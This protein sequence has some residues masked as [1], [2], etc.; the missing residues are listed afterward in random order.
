MARAAKG[1]TLGE[2]ELAFGKAFTKNKGKMSRVDISSISEEKT[3][4][5]RKTGILT[6]EE[7]V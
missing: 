4:I 7:P 2:A 5:V 6:I 1:L 3:Q